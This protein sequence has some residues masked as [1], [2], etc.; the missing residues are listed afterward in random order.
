MQFGVED[1]EVLENKNSEKR[2]RRKR[3][4]KYMQKRINTGKTVP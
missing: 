1:A 4:V 3:D 2:N